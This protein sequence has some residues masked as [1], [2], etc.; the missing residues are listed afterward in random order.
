AIA[1]SIM[2][3][4]QSR[5]V[6]TYGSARW[7]EA[8]DIHSAGLDRPAGVFLGLHDGQYLRHEGPEH[9]LTFAPTR[10]GKSVGLVIP[11]LLSWTGSAVVHDIKKE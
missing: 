7:A 11:T 10:S 1:M 9:V 8:A 4:R 2:R 5:L 3:S 6:T